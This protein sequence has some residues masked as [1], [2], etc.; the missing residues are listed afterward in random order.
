MSKENVTSEPYP[1][2]VGCFNGTYFWHKP[3]ESG[4]HLILRTCFGNNIVFNTQC[5]FSPVKPKQRQSLPKP[6]LSHS[7]ELI[8]NW[9]WKYDNMDKAAPFLSIGLRYTVRNFPDRQSEKNIRIAVTIFCN[10]RLRSSNIT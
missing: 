7:T 4:D 1:P 8:S 2:F 6:L 5:Q 10:I 3:T 9:Q